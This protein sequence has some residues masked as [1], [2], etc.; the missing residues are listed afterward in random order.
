MTN[1]EL[2]EIELH[3]AFQLAWDLLV[4][5]HGRPP[6]TDTDDLN[7]CGFSVLAYGKLGGLELGYGSD[8]DLVF[9][10]DDSRNQGSTNGNRP[11]DALVFYIRLAQRMISF[12]NTITS[13]GILYEVDMRLRPN[14]ESGLLVTSVSGFSDYQHDDAWTWE[15][16]ALV[17]ARCV[18]GDLNLAQQVGEIRQEVLAK[19]RDRDIITKE[20]SDMRAK[21]RG[22]LDKSS[23]QLFDLKQGVGGITD[24]E[25][26]VQYAVLVWS[27]DFPELLLYTDNIRILS[28]LMTTDKLNEQDGTLL[29]DA[30][31]FYRKQANLC[32]LQE[33]P[34]IV[35]LSEVEQYQPRIAALWQ[36]WF[37]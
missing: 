26:M 22:L 32:V 10:Y 30:Y 35:S 5:K 37:A 14:G 17:R 6:C 21:M 3:Q 1:C 23:G 27:A 7:K 4:E 28:T 31:R 19:Q 20:V 16:Q 25:F 13:S 34:A 8:L 9:I 2:A 15:H 12:L 18:T 29:A 11:L 33:M 24:I 36:Q